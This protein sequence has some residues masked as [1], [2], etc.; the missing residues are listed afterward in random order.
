[1]NDSKNH[2]EE[3]F[4]NVLSEISDEKIEK[5]VF[6]K[7]KSKVLTF[8]KIAA[9]AACLA[10]V[11]GTAVALKQGGG[12]V[13]GET[14]QPAALTTEKGTTSSS[15]LTD[16]SSPV[17]SQEPTEESVV[18]EEEWKKLPFD[19][20]YEFL[21]FETE[22]ENSGRITPSE[23]ALKLLKK[24]LCFGYL[25]SKRRDISVEV[26]EVG[27][28]SK[29]FAVA[30]RPEGEK[31]FYLFMNP[32]YSPSDFGTL[33]GDLSLNAALETSGPL[34]VSKTEL[35]KRFYYCNEDEKRQTELKAMLLD[36]FEENKNLAPVLPHYALEATDSR[37][38]EKN[39]EEMR[40]TLVLGEIELYAVVEI[41]S[42]GYVLV[43]LGAN[44]N[45][46]FE[47]E[48]SD[49]K[50]FFAEVKSGAEKAEP[51]EMLTSSPRSSA[52]SSGENS[53]TFATS[54]TSAPI[55]E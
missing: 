22:Y 24:S 54:D 27:A 16:G 14:K 48:K 28:Y 55:S 3:Y 42:D 32:M 25:G 45:F 37:N 2:S 31:N 9:A 34:G 49:V 29:N 13:G 20:K 8:R 38:T 10:V 5:A 7:S 46:G 50:A 6:Y 19:E 33:F 30:V 51:T 36:L 44:S 21:E 53:S 52:S 26:F 35:G 18:S 39:G 12:F 15:L 47:F 17:I 11:V 41:Y 23:S 40:F 4:E 43:D 1:M